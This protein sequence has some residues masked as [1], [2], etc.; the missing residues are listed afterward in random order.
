MS[1]SKIKNL[2]MKL[3]KKSKEHI[4]KEPL[5][6]LKPSLLLKNKKNAKNIKMINPEKLADTVKKEE[7]G[8]EEVVVIENHPIQKDVS[9]DLD[10]MMTTQFMLV[11]S[12][13]KLPK[14]NSE[15]ILNNMERS[16]KLELLKMKKKNQKVS[17]MSS[18]KI[19]HLLKTLLSVMEVS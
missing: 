19:K 16:K 13:S 6:L 2:W 10:T 17:V 1:D 3:W 8:E 14:W 18:L 9:T 11:I 12:V 5:K 7:V 4:W 15:D